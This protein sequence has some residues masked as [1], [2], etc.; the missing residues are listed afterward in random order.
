MAHAKQFKTYSEQVELLR[1]RGMHMEDDI[2]AE[3]LLARLNYYRLSGYW[4]PMRRFS[5]ESDS[6]LDEF[7]EGASFELAV[8][9][10]EFDERL[11]HC[12]FTELDRIEMAVRTMLGHELGRIHPLIHLD[13]NRLAAL[14]NQRRRDGRTKYDAWLGKFKAAVGKSQ[15]DFVRHHE[16]KYGGEIPIWVAVEIMD[17]G[18]ALPSLRN[19]SESSS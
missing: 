11:R 16:R 2:R 14:A 1:T 5:P 19:V 18:N 3:H 15:E 17:L 9:L 8:A 6:A 7:V 13:A 12:V 4:Y 10:Y